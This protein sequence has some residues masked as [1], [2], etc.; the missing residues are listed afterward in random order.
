MRWL[1]DPLN[2]QRLSGFSNPE[3]A[4]VAA[5]A[6][7]TASQ[8]AIYAANKLFGEKGMIGGLLGE[9]L[10]GVPGMIAGLTVGPATRLAAEHVG[11]RGFK[12]WVVH[13]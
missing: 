12:N 10:G 11:S 8:K 2:P 1:S 4:A 7:P 5:A 3:K 9:H 13:G 6:V